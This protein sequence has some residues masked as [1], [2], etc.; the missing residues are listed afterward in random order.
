MASLRQTLTIRRS[1]PEAS[2]ARLATAELAAYEARVGQYDAAQALVEELRQSQYWGDPASS[3]A[4]FFAEAMIGLQDEFESSALDRLMRAYAVA[5][6][7]GQGSL[8]RRCAAW[9]AHFRFNEGQYGSFTEWAAMARPPAPIVEPDEAAARVSLDLAVAHHLV[10][11]DTLADKRF[12]LARRYATSV[13]DDSYLA[14]CLYNR[15]ACG[16]SRARLEATSL[17]V[18]FGAVSRLEIEN[19]SALN[20]AA[21]TGNKSAKYLQ[22]LG[23]AR[24][25]LLRG[26]GARAV[27]VLVAVRS[28]LPEAKHP[29]L[30][31]QIDADLAT[32]ALL[33][34]RDDLAL[35]LSRTLNVQ[36]A[37]H[38]EPDDRVVYLHQLAA[39]KRFIGDLDGAVNAE[40]LSS[41]A[42]RQVADTVSN[43]RLLQQE[44]QNW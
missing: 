20:Y 16:I 34:G 3:V 29:R 23:Q 22:E 26:D 33:S 4:I 19:S 9:I 21:A 35:E 12:A 14:F 7:M 36:D 31:V 10:G 43:L 5:R 24:L 30:R 17:G 6:G 38:L 44:L 27:E 1:S 32:A 42:R 18:D 2:E 28:E 39:L 25:A 37:Q 40:T 15:P 8:A 11:E 41:S 13:G